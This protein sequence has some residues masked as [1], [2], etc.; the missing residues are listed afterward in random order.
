MSHTGN[1][2]Q[3]GN[4]FK[5]YQR[6]VATIGEAQN[7]LET[8]YRKFGHLDGH[9][10]LCSESATDGPSDGPFTARVGFIP[11]PY[12]IEA[13]ERVDFGQLIQQMNA[14]EIAN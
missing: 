1:G 9:N 8:F 2:E 11:W 7:F 14:S 4:Q 10:Y 6:R 5:R 3:G 12:P 13:D